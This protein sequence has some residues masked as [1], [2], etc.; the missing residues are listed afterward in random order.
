MDDPTDVVIAID[1][2]TNI[3]KDNAVFTFKGLLTKKMKTEN[4]FFIKVS[5]VC[6]IS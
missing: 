1:E 6:D 2:F 4:Y 3:Y 5:I